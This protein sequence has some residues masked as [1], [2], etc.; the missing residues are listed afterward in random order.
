MA[1]RT[2]STGSTCEAA[3]RFAPRDGLAAALARLPELRAFGFE[4]VRC[5]FFR[6]PVFF[7]VDFRLAIFSP[8]RCPAPCPALDSPLLAGQA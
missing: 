7:R 2:G 8:P 5:V 4:A 6:L 1:S 3:S